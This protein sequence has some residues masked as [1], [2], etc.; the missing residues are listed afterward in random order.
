[1]EWF[2]E[3]YYVVDNDDRKLYFW[4]SH[5][6]FLFLLWFLPKFYLRSKFSLQLKVIPIFPFLLWLSC[7]FYLCSKF[8]VQF[9]RH[10]FIYL[11]F[12]HKLSA[13]FHENVYLKWIFR[14]SHC[15]IYVMVTAWSQPAFTY[16]KATT[17][18]LEQ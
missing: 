10:L 17:E 5:L 13:P 14:A 12:T 6:F 4:K 3:K 15:R 18:T 2:H 16:S 9:C 11:C 7:K 1:M 8:S